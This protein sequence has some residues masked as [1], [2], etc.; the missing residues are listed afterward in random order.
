MS[1][2]VSFVLTDRLAGFLLLWGHEGLCSF[3]FPF[4]PDLPDVAD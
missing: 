2:S 3:S 4:V 1:S